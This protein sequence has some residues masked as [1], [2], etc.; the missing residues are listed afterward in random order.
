[1]L[2]INGFHRTVPPQNS[3]NAVDIAMLLDTIGGDTELLG[4]LA[5]D[6]L[7]VAD[8]QLAALEEAVNSGE[9]GM[10]REAAH[11][12]K[13]SSATLGANRL[14]VMCADLERQA[15]AGS[16]DEGPAQVRAILTEFARVKDELVAYVP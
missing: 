4:E 11:S 9:A 1:M 13:G 14:S 10:A 7:D 15:R 5:Q 8:E 3:Q 2:G 6:F 16:L 12:L